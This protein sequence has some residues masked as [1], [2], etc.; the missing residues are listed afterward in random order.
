MKNIGIITHYGVHNHGAVLQL[1]ALIK[2]LRNLGYRAQALQFEKNYDF[3]GH[4][5]KEKYNITIK[6]VSIYLRYLKENG[7][8]KTFYNY[9]KRDTL[10]RFKKDNELIGDYYTDSQQLDAVVVGS[11]EVFALHT[12]PTPVFFGHCLPTENV[13]SY[14]GSFGPTKIE[15]IRNL[16]SEAFVRSGLEA[17]KGITVRDNNSASIIEHLLRKRPEIVVDP[18]ILYGFADEISAMNRPMDDNYVVV[19]AYD[20]RMNTAQEIEAIKSFAK[21]HKLKTVSPGFY[22][23]WCD[24]NINTDPITLLSYFKY[25]NS[26]ITDTFHGAVMSIITGANVVVKT[27]ESNYNK[28]SNLMSEYCLNGRIC[29]DF[30]NLD[31]IFEIPIQVDKVVSEIVRRRR[32]S[33]ALLT[34]MLKNC[35]V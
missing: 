6:S 11:D 8:S 19:Y 4:E 33:M 15:D 17:M 28:L 31:R 18:V 25:A 12:G 30:N 7:T 22:H 13:I 24:K 21:R 3:M 10:R 20:D 27:R 16:H 34:N 35:H 26:V 23:G 14:A 1:T 9:K 2:V 32:D 5:L 29:Q